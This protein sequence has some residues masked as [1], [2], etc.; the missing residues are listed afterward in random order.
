MTAVGD[1]WNAERAAFSIGL[2]HISAP[3]R[4]RIPGGD[5]PVHPHRHLR[6][7]LRGQR[8]LP[9]DAGSPTPSVA[10]RHLPH[11]DQRVRPGTQHHLLQRPDP[12][13]VLFPRRLEDPPPQP[14][15][16]A[17]VGP[18]VDG[19]PLRHVLRSVHRHGVQLVLRFER[20]CQHRCSKAHLPTSA[21]LRARLP[22]AGIR[23]VMPRRSAGGADEIAAGFLVAFRLPAFAS[24]ASCSRRG[25]PLSSRSAYR[26]TARTP[27]GVSTFRTFE[28]R[29]DWAPSLPRDPAVLS[30]PVRSLRPPLAPSTRS[31]ALSLRYSSHL[32]ELSLTGRR[33]GFTRVR[34]PG[35]PPSLVDPRMEQRP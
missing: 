13:P 27:A 30:R 34:P 2:R 25:F 9:V 8:Q 1:H 22:R 28:T 14:R 3:D 33:Q 26:A 4:Q 7:I 31:Q 11:A 6:P 23:P 24:W 18:P 5:R 32:P 35:L 15:Y 20:P 29:P 21:P 12:R 10:L 19:V 16:V 17:L